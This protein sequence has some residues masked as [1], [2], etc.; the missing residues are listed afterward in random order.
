[1][2]KPKKI[3]LGQESA[4]RY[5]LLIKNMTD[6]F[7]VGVTLRLHKTQ[8]EISSLDYICVFCG[9]VADFSINGKGICFACKKEIKKEKGL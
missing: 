5:G 9:S 6:Y 2:K 3:Y 8:I 4:Y 1:V 7:R